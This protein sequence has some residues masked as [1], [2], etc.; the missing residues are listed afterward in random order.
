MA[1]AYGPPDPLFPM[2]R[3]RRGF[4]VIQT[5]AGPV[6]QK[7]PRPRTKAKQGWDY[8]RQT[9]WGIAARWASSPIGL[10]RDGSEKVARDCQLVWRDILMRASYGLLIAIVLEDGTPLVPWRIINPNPQ[11][12]LDLVTDTI[13]SMLYRAPIGWVGVPPGSDGDV[14]TMVS[15]T[16][17]WIAG[18]AIPNYEYASDLLDQ[19]GADVGSVLYRGDD[20]WVVLEPGDAGQLITMGATIPEWAD[21]PAPPTVVT[22]P[23]LA[24]LLR[25]DQ[26]SAI[27]VNTL[28]G[29]GMV[30]RAGQIITG[31]HGWATA[32]AAT[33][34]II[35]AVYTQASAAPAALVA[36][37]PQV[38][39]IAIGL[40]T[41]P[42]TTPYT[43]PSN[44]LYYLCVQTT[45]V[46]WN[47][48]TA[49]SDIF[50]ATIS[51]S[52]ALPNPF[53]TPTQSFGNTLPKIWGY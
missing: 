14:L 30:L 38:T 33:A 23:S 19:I 26:S 48:A 28:G 11:F 9:E 39:G 27:N 15:T 50:S 16:P 40:Q 41:W 25:I 10:E 8:Y 31:L 4:L 51:S 53:G 34:K 12:I 3:K 29:T 7:W 24:G 35:P 6:A 36:S 1:R 32:A 45:V 47:Q 21:A 18:Y 44:G 17:E 37:G 49:A 20:G 13:G 2:P 5:K 22:L 43:V 52:G 42:L 46:G